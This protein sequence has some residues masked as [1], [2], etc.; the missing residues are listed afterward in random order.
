MNDSFQSVITS[1]KRKQ[2][3]LVQHSAFSLRN[4]FTCDAKANLYFLHEIKSVLAVRDYSPCTITV[5][6]TSR[7]EEALL[8]AIPLFV[9]P[10]CHFST[11]LS[12]LSHICAPSAVPVGEK[13]VL[14]KRFF[15]LNF[16]FFF[17]IVILGLLEFLA[18][19]R[20]L[21]T[22]IQ[23]LYLLLEESLSVHLF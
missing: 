22:T 12:V 6:K 16:L 18:G 9:F 11:L 7:L 15:N 19:D 13:Q 1:Q 5:S 23:P 4:Q 2:K 3:K 21:N 14:L 20:F 10:G 17:A 8:D